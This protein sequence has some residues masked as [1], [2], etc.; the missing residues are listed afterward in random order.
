M[1]KLLSL[2]LCLLVAIFVV[3]QEEKKSSA[4]KTSAQGGKSKPAAGK[5]KPDAVKKTAASRPKPAEA[6]EDEAA[7]MAELDSLKD[8]ATGE[9]VARL[10]AFV[11]AHPQGGGARVRA[12]ELLAGARAALGDERL[13][14]GDRAG[15]VALFRKVVEGLTPDASDKLFVEVVSRLP[16]NLYATG[17]RDEGLDLARRVEA[18]A[19]GNAKRLLGVAGFYLSV[20]LAD[21]AAR[22]AEEAARLAPES[23]A[24]RQAL[25][26]AHRQALRL[27]RAAEEFARALELEPNSSASRRSLADLRRATGK[28]D[29]A[30]L[31]YRRQLEAEPQD[32]G[33]RAGLVLSLFEAGRREEGETELLK[34]LA[35]QPDNL[36][37]FVGAAYLFA[38]EGD[39]ARALDFAGRAVGLEPRLRWV[40]ARLAY[41]RA[42][43]AQKRPLEAEQAVLL[44]R[45]LG[46]FPTL[47]YELATALAASGR[48]DEAAE[49]LAKTFALKDGQVETNLAGRNL[50]RAADFIEL[51]A[52][53]RR[54]SL[55]QHKPADTADN[56]RM[57]KALLAFHLA[58]GS[59]ESATI[60][61]KGAAAAGLE[62]VAGSDEMRAFRQLYVAGKLLERGAALPSV[63]ERTDEAMSGVDAATGAPAAVVAL[64]ADELRERRAQARSMGAAMSLP[65]VSR[66]VMSKILRGRIEDLAGWALY[67]QG[68]SA[69]AVVR[70]KRALSVLPTTTVWWRSAAWHLGAAHEASGNQRDAL[71][72]YV[73]VYKL[74]PDPARRTVIESLYRRINGTTDG[75]E[76]L[77]NNPAEVASRQRPSATTAAPASVEPKQTLERPATEPDKVAAETTP[78]P[79][80]TPTPS[81]EEPAPLPTPTP[82]ATPAAPEPTAMPTPEPMPTPTPEPTPTPTPS[83]PETPESPAPTPTPTPDATA[84]PMTVAANTTA[85]TTAEATPAKPTT[86]DGACALTISEEAVSLQT[87]GGSAVVTV[88]LG[89]AGDLSKVS[90]RTV[91]W[92]DIVI[93]AEPRK[94]DD[95]TAAQRYSI[96]SVS[97]K[98]GRYT[99]TFTSPCGKRDVQVEV[100]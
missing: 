9:R 16:A 95:D 4:G 78:T 65:S 27:E 80:A 2:S 55:F 35:E 33:A 30:L 37:L 84:T 34:T 85:T 23:A 1:R 98:P 73:G 25:G 63:V 31:L 21:D 64:F 39:A 10:E 24:A 75:L 81:P 17:H 18:K 58:V 13:R 40:W 66:D 44:A 94:P 83:A 93:L 89:G 52:P 56:A 19:A 26:A 51:L 20:E 70:L 71:A 42:M 46:R 53:E 5:S 12:T 68:N 29:A 28:P 3:A 91:N 7:L 45:E 60:D 59:S 77:L 50:A 32:A 72:S 96:S 22:A 54:A 88:G 69:E 15:G 90:A 47:D 38:S 11:A 36:P 86:G 92:A 62:F 43:L 76:R 61:E 82:D 97:G 87:G 74:A 6:K 99:V 49:E 57:L 14:A 48:Y 67:K 8:L 79:A 41:A 100:K